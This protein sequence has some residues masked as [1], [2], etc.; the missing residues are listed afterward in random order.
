MGILGLMTHLSGKGIDVDLRESAK[1]RTIL[2]DGQSLVFSLFQKWIEFTS[3]ELE[4]MVYPCYSIVD[5]LLSG[6][7]ELFKQNKIELIW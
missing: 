7:S 6:F 2:V 5:A 1:N 4:I 3:C